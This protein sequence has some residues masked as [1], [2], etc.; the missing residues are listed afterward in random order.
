MTVA[1]ELYGPDVSSYLDILFIEAL[2]SVSES[3]IL[4]TLELDKSTMD[5]Q[6]SA[7]NLL[8]DVGGK[9]G[10]P[11]PQDR[12]IQCVSSIPSANVRSPLANFVHLSLTGSPRSECRLGRMFSGVP[13][14]TSGRLPTTCAN[15]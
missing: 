10:G 6:S 15:S 2:L 13:L 1:I 4:D 11:R 9:P 14:P 12:V 7:A 3:I 5:V 8:P